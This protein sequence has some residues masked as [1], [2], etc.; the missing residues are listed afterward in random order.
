[1]VWIL[2]QAV[3]PVW[4]MLLSGYV[5]FGV[6]LGFKFSLVAFVLSWSGKRRQPFVRWLC[7]AALAVS[8]VGGALVY[9]FVRNNHNPTPLGTVERVW[10]AMVV[11]TFILSA[12]AVW[13]SWPEPGTVR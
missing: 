4:M 10:A 13:R 1:M 7:T 5:L 12:A 8:F 2:A 9:L 6:P 11:G 3:P